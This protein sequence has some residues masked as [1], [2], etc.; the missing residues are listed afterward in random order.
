M[1]EELEQRDADAALEAGED[2]PSEP[3]VRYVGQADVRELTPE[4]CHALGGSPEDTDGLLWARSVGGEEHS[5]VTLARFQEA[6]GDGWRK[7]LQDNPEDFRVDPPDAVDLEEAMEFEIGG[8]MPAE[9]TDGSH[10]PGS[11]EPGE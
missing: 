2:E 9:G 5:T 10:P 8:E 6:L 4:T 3:V 11:S 1:D 7:V